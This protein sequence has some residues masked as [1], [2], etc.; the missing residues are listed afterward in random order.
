[1][2]LNVNAL[3]S[4][5]D[6]EIVHYADRDNP[7]I[8]ELCR[9]LELFIDGGV[10]T[11]VFI[12]LNAP[13]TC[14]QHEPTHDQPE[15]NMKPSNARLLKGLKA[16][17]LTTNQVRKKFGISSVAACVND[18]RELGCEIETTLLTV[19]NRYGEPAGA[20]RYRLV[21]APKRLVRAATLIRIAA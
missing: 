1:M 15:G 3:R 2:S 17:P 13:N 16:G 9:R 5:T 11:P 7:V 12:S 10:S 8:N 21:R 6:E 19:H 18:L 20:A 14:Q 4:Y